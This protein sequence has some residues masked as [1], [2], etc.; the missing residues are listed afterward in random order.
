[1][2]VL[3]NVKMLLWQVDTRV[4]GEETVLPLSQYLPVQMLFKIKS[5]VNSD[6]VSVVLFFSKA[7]LFLL[8]FFLKNDFSLSTTS[9][10][11]RA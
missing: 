11:Q 8:S 9:E 5:K 1:M 3:L 7:T 6:N 4:D 10:F 2:E